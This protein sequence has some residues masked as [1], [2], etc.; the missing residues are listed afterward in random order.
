MNAHKFA[1]TLSENG[2]LTL[3]GLPIRAGESV[4]V[5]ILEQSQ[6]SQPLPVLQ[7]EHPLRGSVIRYDEPFEP[8]I[9]AED[10]D[11]LQ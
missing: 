8:V 10:W 9:A 7:S 6:Q 2:T 4:E 5:I 1:V 3:N 11:V